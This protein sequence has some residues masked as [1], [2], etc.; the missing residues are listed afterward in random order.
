LIAQRRGFGAG[1]GDQARRTQRGLHRERERGFAGQ[2]HLH[3]A[4]D[5]GLD[6][7]EDERRPAAAQARHRVEQ[8]LGHLHRQP[9]RAEERPDD[10]G[11][12]RAGVLST[13]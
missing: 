9:H 12:R 13:A 4:V 7:Q 8:P 1:L 3:P 10:L 11:V 6:H 2:P 5:Q